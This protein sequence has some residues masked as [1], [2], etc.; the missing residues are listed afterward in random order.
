MAGIS[1]A[2]F[3]TPRAQSSLANYIRDR[4]AQAMRS[5]IKEATASMTSVPKPLKFLRGHYAT[6]KETLE[7]VASGDNRRG[8]TQL[9]T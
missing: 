7:T 4:H 9:A 8:R 1:A 3:S 6:L 5:A 2:R